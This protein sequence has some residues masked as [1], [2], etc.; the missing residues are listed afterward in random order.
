MALQGGK[1]VEV[2]ARYFEEFA[3]G[4]TFGSGQ[5][6]IDEEQI[7]RLAGEFDPQPFHLDGEAARDTIFCGLAASGW[8]GGAHHAPWRSQACGGVALAATGTSRRQVAR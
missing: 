7:R 1:E 5:L 4:Q 6:R 2:T 8:H 3:V